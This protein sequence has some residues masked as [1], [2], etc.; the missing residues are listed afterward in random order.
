MLIV[1]AE[2][3][4]LGPLNARTGQ[5]IVRTLEVLAALVRS[6]EERASVSDGDDCRVIPSVTHSDTL[7]PL[8]QSD[9]LQM[10]RKIWE[11]LTV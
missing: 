5:F 9:L 3:D 8:C 4:H 10:V 6:I 1:S 7:L 2:N 11:M